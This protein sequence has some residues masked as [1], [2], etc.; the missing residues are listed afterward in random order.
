M[1]IHV[2]TSEKER[3]R[4]NLERRLKKSYLKRTRIRITTDF[5]SWICNQ[6]ERVE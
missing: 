2:R 4:E 5:L 6:G 1:E 3:Q